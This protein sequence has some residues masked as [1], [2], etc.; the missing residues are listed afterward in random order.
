MVTDSS[1]G[2]YVSNTDNL[3][4]KNKASNNTTNYNITA[5]NAYGQIKIIGGG[6]S[7][8]NTDPTANFEY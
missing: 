3:I 8:V 7:F 2:I 6:G 1:T 4:I 5:G